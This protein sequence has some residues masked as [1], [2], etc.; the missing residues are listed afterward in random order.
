MA[1]Q[2][3]SKLGKSPS[4]TDAMVVRCRVIDQAFE[5]LGQEVAALR[6]E[7]QA[8][9]KAGGDSARLNRLLSPGILQRAAMAAGVGRCLD[10]KDAGKPERLADAVAPLLKIAMKKTKEAA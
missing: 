9:M 7:A 2:F 8:M 5:V 1:V 3:G 4:P 6:A 10:I